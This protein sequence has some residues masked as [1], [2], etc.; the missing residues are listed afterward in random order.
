M[1]G[2]CAHLDHLQLFYLLV[3]RY[4]QLKVNQ[5][6]RIKEAQYL[7]DTFL[8]PDAPLSPDLG[9]DVPRQ[10]AS[11]ACNPQKK[12]TSV[13]IKSLFDAAAQMCLDSIAE[14]LDQFNKT[15]RLGLGDLHGYSQVGAYCV[16]GQ[17]HE[18]VGD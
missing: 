18:S 7:Y 3:Q 4:R 17:T 13:D 1:N 12:D 11:S 2:R 9:G 6:E 5:S 15:L 8:A 16:D 10:Q 14:S